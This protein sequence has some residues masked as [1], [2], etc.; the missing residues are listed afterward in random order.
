MYSPCAEITGGS[1]TIGQQVAVADKT[2]GVPTLV[3]DGDGDV[4]W[5]LVEILDAA[6]GLGVIS[7][8]RKA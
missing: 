1:A 8:W 4:D 6:S 5:W 2:T 7:S 3:A